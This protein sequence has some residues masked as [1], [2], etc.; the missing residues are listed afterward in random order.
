ML[1]H[2]K[3]YLVVGSIL[4]CIL[5]T[6]FRNEKKLSPYNFPK[7]YMF[8]AMPVNADNYVSNEGVELG[9]MLFYDPIL[10]AD[11]NISC[12]SC[13]KQ[14]FAFSD[15][16]NQF[17]KG[18]N[19]LLQKRNSLPLFNLAWYPAFFADGRAATIE[20][21]VLHPVRTKEEM[22][23]DW[24][25]V[26]KKLNRNDFYKQKF[27]AIYENKIID[28]V[29][30]TKVIGQFLRTLISHTS[31]YDSFLNRNIKLNEDEME[32]F[33]LVNN[34][35]RG[36]CIQC[37]TTDGDGL[38]TT[39]KF[40]N[41]GLDS[42]SDPLLYKDIGRGAVTKNMLDYGKFKIPSLRNL[43]YTA[44][45]MHDGRFK[46]VEE[47]VDFYSEGLKPAVNIDS[48]MEFIHQ[49]GNRLSAEEKRKI[50]CFLKTLSDEAFI[51]NRE[52]G[53]PF[54]HRKK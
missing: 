18:F 52:F 14:Q 10:S 38:T 45:Y 24:N 6:A 2:K 36:D 7:L 32:G 12:A 41:N 11:S 44:P 51:K 3:K 15:A 8:P 49:G 25:E 46:T 17:S 29:A 31:R 33:K 54:A 53:N 43:F 21:A 47:V 19:Q 42:V 50:I 20:D 27:Y 39:L 48:K 4:F 5:L 1:F 30:V 9:R 28:S 40:S 35:T 13:H 34:Q 16:P 22:N 26:S 23:L 37:H